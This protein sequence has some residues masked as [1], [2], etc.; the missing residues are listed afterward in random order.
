MSD[1][2]RQLKLGISSYTEDELVL[3]VI[4]KVNIVGIVSFK[5]WN[6]NLLW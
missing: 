5:Y 1:R 3:D 2:K 6:C 4:G